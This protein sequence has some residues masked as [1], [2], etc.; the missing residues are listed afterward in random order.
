M[1]IKEFT[2]RE[3]LA[4]I[5]VNGYHFFRAG[6]GGHMIYSNG[7]TSISIPTHSKHVNKM[8]FARIAK[9]NGLDLTGGAAR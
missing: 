8:L 1:R 6:K 3:A 7:H 4:I 9:E 5:A 2:T